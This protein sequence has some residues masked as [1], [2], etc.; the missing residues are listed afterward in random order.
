MGKIA[1]VVHYH[2]AGDDQFVFNLIFDRS[3]A[4][5]LWDLLSESAPHADDLA[6]AFG[7]AA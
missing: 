4:K 1:V 2:Q 6:L 5:Y 7:N 3:S